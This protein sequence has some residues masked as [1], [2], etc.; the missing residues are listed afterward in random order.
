MKHHRVLVDHL[1]NRTK[2]ERQTESHGCVLHSVCWK[3]S[4]RVVNLSL[5]GRHV[6]K[7]TGMDERVCHILDDG[8]NS[9][10]LQFTLRTSWCTLEWQPCFLLVIINSNIDAVH[11]IQCQPGRVFKGLSN[12]DLFPFLFLGQYFDLDSIRCTCGVRPFSDA[13]HIVFFYTNGYETW[14][15]V[16]WILMWEWCWTNKNNPQRQG[17]G[18][19]STCGSLPWTLGW[20]PCDWS[21][22][23]STTK[24]S[25]SILVC[26]RLMQMGFIKTWW[27][28]GGKHQKSNIIYFQPPKNM[29]ILSNRR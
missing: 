12:S 26:K 10:I 9:S 7:N 2:R 20:F 17:E 22:P 4:W 13:W 5:V 14:K 3:Y 25:T 6:K 16:N 15:H 24:G 28:D 23:W 21:F 19:D 27:K 18:R 11:A 29:K 1:I 8:S